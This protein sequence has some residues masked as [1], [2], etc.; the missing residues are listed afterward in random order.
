M[1]TRT[2]KAVMN[3]RLNTFVVA[4]ICAVAIEYRV[5]VLET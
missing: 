5:V 1:K 2:S 3:A 4:T